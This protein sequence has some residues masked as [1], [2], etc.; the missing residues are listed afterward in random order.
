MALTHK[1]F[2]CRSFAISISPTHWHLARTRVYSNSSRALRQILIFKWRIWALQHHGLRAW[3]KL[4]QTSTGSLLVMDGRSSVSH[5]PITIRFST[6]GQVYKERILAKRRP[7]S[8]QLTIFNK[9]YHQVSSLVRLQSQTY[10]N[11][12]RSSR[13]QIHNLIHANRFHFSNKWQWTILIC[14]FWIATG[15]L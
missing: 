15:C 14:D 13:T 4:L 10:H 12:A 5:G 1:I 3:S 2:W 11:S 6:H 9:A 8:F 7:F